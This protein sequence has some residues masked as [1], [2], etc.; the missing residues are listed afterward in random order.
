MALERMMFLFAASV[1]LVM[2]I[3]ARCFMDR[4]TW[5]RHVGNPMTFCDHDCIHEVFKDHCEFLEC[6]LQ[7]PTPEN[8]KKLCVDTCIRGLASRQMKRCLRRSF[9]KLNNRPA[10][11]QNLLL[12]DAY[13]YCEGYVVKSDA[14]GIAVTIPFEE[15]YA[16]V[17]HD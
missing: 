2:A 14:N 7:R 9:P 4:R 13:E 17:Q 10:A 1:I 3:P 6:S 11:F 15:V 5:S 12:Q 8:I 16:L